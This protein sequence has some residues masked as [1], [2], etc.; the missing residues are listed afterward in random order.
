MTSTHPEQDTDEQVEQLARGLA[1]A[2]HINPQRTVPAWDDLTDTDR[3]AYRAD[4]LRTL[5]GDCEVATPVPTVKAVR[6]TVTCLPEDDINSHVFAIDVVYRGAGRWAVQRGEHACLGS[7]GTWAQ[8]VKEYDRGDEWLN[9]HRF[10]LETALKLARDAAP[11]VKVNGYT[12][13]DAI[14]MHTQH[15]EEQL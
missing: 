1:G 9:A 10:G 8:G 2:A 3:E 15:S 4:A 5:T 13:A 11:H 14:A 7:D 6:Y 12:V